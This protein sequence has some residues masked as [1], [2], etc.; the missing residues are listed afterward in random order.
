MTNF[1]AGFCSLLLVACAETAEAPLEHCPVETRVVSN[2]MLLGGLVVDE[3]GAA[4]IA[5]ATVTLHDSI[6][7]TP[8]IDTGTGT[9]GSYRIALSTAGELPSVYRHAVAEGYLDGYLFEG[10]ALSEPQ[11]LPLVTRDHADALHRSVGL[12][13]DVT[14]GMLLVAVTDC[15]GA[16]VAGATIEVPGAERV[17]YLGA[18]TH[19]DAALDRTSIDSAAIVLGIPAGPA[20]VIVERGGG[21][22]EDDTA[23]EIHA[24]ALATRWF[25]P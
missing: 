18:D 1:N 10:A 20:Q 6:D 25:R 5:G 16:P 15:A 12:E 17:L 9:D 3:L 11:I 24:D 4:P 21:R 23:I 19:F 2:P 14:R 8:I 7:G 13:R 22:I